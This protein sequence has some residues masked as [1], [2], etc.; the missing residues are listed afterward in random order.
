MAYVELT[1][2]ARV[3]TV[4]T[5]GVVYGKKYKWYAFSYNTAEEINVAPKTLDVPMG[6]NKDFLYKIGDIDITKYGNSSISILF[7][8][9]TARV[10]LNVDARGAN[11]NKITRL[12]VNIPAGL[13]KTGAFNV[14]E[15]TVSTSNVPNGDLQVLIDRFKYEVGEYHKIAYLHSAEPLATEQDESINVLFPS[16]AI[17]V[18][19]SLS[20]DLNTSTTV[21]TSAGAISF[22][23]SNVSIPIGASGVFKANLLT[24]G[25]AYGGATWA[26]ANLYLHDYSATHRYRFYPHNKQTTD[27]RT[28]FSFG[29]IEPLKYSGVGSVRS[30]VVDACS[31]VYPKDRWKTPNR[32][33]FSN[34]AGSD[35]VITNVLQLLLDI[36]TIGYDNQPNTEAVHKPYPEARLSYKPSSGS[37]WSNRALPMNKYLPAVSLVGITKTPIDPLLSIDL[38]KLTPGD[39]SSVTGL[40]LFNSVH[41]WTGDELIN[42]DLLGLN[43]VSVGSQS[44][45]GLIKEAAITGERRKAVVTSDITNISALGAIK[46]LK[47][48]FKN[49]RCVRNTNWNPNAEG[50][51]PNPV[52][53]EGDKYLPQ[54]LINLGI[55][56]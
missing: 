2:N 33:D 43:I 7:E 34:M 26:P 37:S 46:V 13:L 44:Y 10:A 1:A 20:G 24:K 9:K 11:A 6:I 22:S 51:D 56:L 47:S 40:N 35:G 45:L 21:L 8:R 29:G 14:K 32:A 50:Y 38:F 18:S 55:E 39:L 53:S 5:V 30:K 42:L 16:F 28:F 52:Y 31:F 23:F 15:Q 17:E 54:Q 25:I 36:L 27:Y 19:N 4:D 12:Q 3:N 49:I 41:L 48:N